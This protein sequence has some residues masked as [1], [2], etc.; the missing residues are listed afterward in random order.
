MI[1]PGLFRWWVRATLAETVWIS[2]SGSGCSFDL[3]HARSFFSTVWTL[4]PCWTYCPARL[5]AVVLRLPTGG[6]RPGRLDLAGHEVEPCP[7]GGAV[8]GLALP[9]S[10]HC[11]SSAVWRTPGPSPPSHW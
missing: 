7:V 2:S 11:G 1:T 4:S 8:S 6:R 3:F 5:A 9:G 10:S